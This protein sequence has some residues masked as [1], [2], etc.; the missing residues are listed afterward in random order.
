[1]FILL[2]FSYF[3][4]FLIFLIIIISFFISIQSSITKK[5]VLNLFDEQL[6]N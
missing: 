3:K 4:P 1:M 2:A 5:Y 6:K